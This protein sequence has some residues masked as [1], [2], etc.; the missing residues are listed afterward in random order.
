MQTGLHPNTDNNNN[1][2][3]NNINNNQGGR[4]WGNVGTT[5]PERSRSSTKGR[6]SNISLL[7]HTLFC[8]K[9]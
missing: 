5:F 8:R 9:T 4:S 6:T 7:Q 1:M 3:N 2:E